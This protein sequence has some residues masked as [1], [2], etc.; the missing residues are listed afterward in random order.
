MDNNDFGELKIDTTSFNGMTKLS[1]AMNNKSC[2]ISYD[3]VTEL[4][5]AVTTNNL[6]NNAITNVTSA[7]PYTNEELKCYTNPQP[8][9]TTYAYPVTSYKE[10]INKKDLSCFMRDISLVFLDAA[11]GKDSKQVC[12][13]M[14]TYLAAYADALENDTK[15]EESETE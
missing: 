10:T 11:N 12:E 1:K 15:Y 14:S 8:I 3:D 6:I 9:Y 7:S 2:L 13:T 5:N 4:T